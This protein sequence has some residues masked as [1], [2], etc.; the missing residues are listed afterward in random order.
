MCHP[1]APGE[2]RPKQWH[3]GRLPRARFTATTALSP[4]KTTK[5]LH[6]QAGAVAGTSS[7]NEVT[8]S[9]PTS[10]AVAGPAMLEGTPN[11]EAARRTADQSAIFIT[12]DAMKIAARTIRIRSMG[13]HRLHAAQRH[14]KQIDTISSS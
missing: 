10:T 5:A 12:P 7:K 11:S 2:N 3:D 14:N 13:R 6:P 1:I 9:A 4:V 8:S